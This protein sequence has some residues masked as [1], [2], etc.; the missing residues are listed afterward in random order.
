M[1]K[2]DNE[3]VFTYISGDQVKR[4]SSFI[5][6]SLS[7]QVT[8]ALVLKA[9]D[10]GK[11]DLTDSVNLYLSFSPAN[12]TAK[13]IPDSVTISQLL[14]NTSGLVSAE[15]SPVF[16][17][18]SQFR[19]SNYGYTLL[20]K[21]L[22]KV[23]QQPF[24]AQVNALNE[25]AG[26]AGL[27]ASSG[28][29]SNI[30]NAYPSLLLGQTE[31]LQQQADKRIANYAPSDIEITPALIPAG[32]MI[33]SADAYSHFQYALFSGQLLSP[34]S[35]AALTT[36]Y[37]ARPHRWSDVSYGYGTQL[38]Q[39]KGITEY[40]HSGYLPGYV[41]LALYY[42]QSNI[43]LVILENTAWDVSDRERTF[44]LHDKL[45]DSIRH[46]LVALEDRPV[47]KLYQAGKDAITATL[48]TAK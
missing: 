8:A 2:R 37:A 35:L 27:H 22:E 31:T 4:Q 3:P 5:I 43:N 40:S 48:I 7:K 36:R 19:Y 17:P 47:A 38:N 33:A 15:Q 9:V 18:G 10:E 26:L 42:P 13:S 45:R 11:L 29:T 14:S 34:K 44:A 25:Q 1:L 24:A 39:Y 16:E 6:A 46:K 30:K 28:K 21:I 20:G 32:G 23:N 41:S 12:K